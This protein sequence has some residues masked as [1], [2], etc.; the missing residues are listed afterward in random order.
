ME[1]PILSI[2]IPTYN[3]APYLEK[4]L[5]SIVED[6]VFL[7]TD[8]VEII[9]SNNC[10][11][12]NTDEICEK[13]A[14]KFPNKIK[15]IRQEEPVYPD[16]HIFKTIEY[17]S[18]IYCKLNNDT[19]AFNKNAL[20]HMLDF[21]KNNP[22]YHGIFFNFNNI[23]KEEVVVC[24]SFEKL[25]NTVSY[26]ITWIVSFCIKRETYN[27]IPEPLRCAKLKLSQVDI[28]GWLIEHNYSIVVYNENLFTVNL[29]PKK[30]ANY[31]IA[32]VFG[33]NYF[34]ILSYYV[35]KNN[36]LSKESIEKEKKQ[37]LKFIN[38]FYFDLN[39]NFS[40]I[41][42]GYFS[43]MFPIYK[44]KPY[45]YLYYFSNIFTKFKNLFYKIDK[46][47][48]HRKICIFSCIKFNI[49]RKR[50]KSVKKDGV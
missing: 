39:N 27:L 42:G 11:T 38:S 7:N 10:S 29:P 46:T 47:D 30:G 15:Y 33:K 5:I 19:A 32:E 9:I 37:I 2:C 43:Y 3:R 20:K 17:A 41:K 40:F 35:N 23:K 26:Y 18:G 1:A 49:R 28:W 4:T 12:D 22:N 50:A 25:L 44:S 13:F 21:L 45:F 16:Y 8:D 6:E 14:Q 34:T 36:G 48:T 24:D 31:N